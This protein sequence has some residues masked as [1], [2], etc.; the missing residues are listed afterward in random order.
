MVIGLVN[1]VLVT[2]LRVPAFI[3]TLTML[4]IGRGLVLGLTGGKNIAY[5]AKAAGLRLRSSRSVRP[6]PSAS[7]TRS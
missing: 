3:A 5:P 6:M 7:T 4:L 2:V 1:G